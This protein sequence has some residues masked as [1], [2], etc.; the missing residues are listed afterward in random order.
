MVSLP[1]I[2]IKR[3]D[4]VGYSYITELNYAMALVFQLGYDISLNST[5]W[6]TEMENLR[7]YAKAF[8][9]YHYEQVYVRRVKT[10]EK[11]LKALEKEKSQN[12]NRINNLTKKV[13]NTGKKIGKETE[14]AKIEAYESEIRTL[15][16]D[17]KQ[18]MDTLPG[19]ESKITQLKTRVDQNRTE[20]H[21]YLGTIEGF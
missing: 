1:A 10:L 20:S 12:M 18:L 11:E 15:E 3:G 9:T 6:T 21:T 2:A 13:N 16:A 4:L 7:N 8:M 17:V 5:E 19:L 14:T